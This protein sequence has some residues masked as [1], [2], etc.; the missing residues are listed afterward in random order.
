M[1]EVR[2]S[3]SLTRDEVV[4]KL[5]L[6]FSS[7]KWEHLE[8][9]TQDRQFAQIRTK[10]TVSDVMFRNND[11]DPLFIDLHLKELG[12]TTQ[13]II[14][15]ST[16]GYLLALK[17]FA[18]PALWIIVPVFAV[19]QEGWWILLKLIPTLLLIQLFLWWVHRSYTKKT[20]EIIDELIKTL[21]P[22]EVK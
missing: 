14:T 12:Q 18:L 16:Q 21:T 22:F 10:R 3:V 9:A 15:P 1:K 13:L 20:R 11:F 19:Y 2:L 17:I 8:L 6:V 5:R 4:E 7:E